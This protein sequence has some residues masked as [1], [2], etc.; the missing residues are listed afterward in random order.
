MRR[1]FRDDGEYLTLQQMA[2]KYVVS[3]TFAYNLLIRKRVSLKAF[4]LAVAKLR[5]MEKER[6]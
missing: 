2:D 6:N 3:Q 1:V 5:M 4:K